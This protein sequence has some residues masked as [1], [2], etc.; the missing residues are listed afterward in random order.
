NHPRY[1][2]LS[3]SEKTQLA[4]AW[5]ETSYEMASDES[6][7]DTYLGAAPWSDYLG[8]GAT[9]L[10]IGC[11]LGGKT[12]RWLERYRGA[13]IHGIDIHPE[14]ISVAESFARLHNAKAHFK[15]NFAE[16]LDFPDGFFDIILSENTFEHVRD[17][18]KVMEECSRVLKDRGLLAVVFPGFWGPVSH[19]LNLVSSTPCLHWFFKYPSLMK[20]YRAVLEQRGE[21]SLWYRPGSEHPLP[22]E[23]GLTLNGTSAT[24]FH[25]MIKGRWNIL[26]DGYKQRSRTKS[27][28]KNVILTGLQMCPVPFFRELLPIAY[29]LQKK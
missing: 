4:L 13:E 5:A 18:R 15:V 9:M 10:D 14:F 22:D 26:F 2:S 12:V 16:Q 11:Y 19:H 23:R 29:V 27:A 24:Q 6:S 8:E 17:I 1:L 20:A 21:A 28:L 3:E 7:F 25:V